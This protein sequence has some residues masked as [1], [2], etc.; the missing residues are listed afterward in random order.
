MSEDRRAGLVYSG[1]SGELVTAG[2]ALGAPCWEPQQQERR[3]AA[4]APQ[5][6]KG[7]LVMA[8]SLRRSIQEGSAHPKCSC[9]GASVWQ[10]AADVLG[11]G[12]GWSTALG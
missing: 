7:P 1:S 11:S 4:A 10:M 6:T 3:W 12:T 5:S 8:L 2:D 9:R